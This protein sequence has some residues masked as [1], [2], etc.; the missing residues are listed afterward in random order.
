MIRTD[1]LFRLI[2]DRRLQLGLSQSEVGRRSLGQSDGSA[3]QNIRRGS[4]PTFENL[5]KICEVLGLRVSI[6]PVTGRSESG[7]SALCL[8]RE[9]CADYSPIPILDVALAAGTGRVNDHEVI[10]SHLA[11][12]SD[13]LRGLGLSAASSVVARAAGESMAPTIHDG[14]A[15][16]IDRARAIPPQH[17]REAKDSRPA[18]IYALFDENGARIKRLAVSSPGV[19]ALL[20]D[21]PEYPPDFLPADQVHIIGRVMWW[22]HTNRED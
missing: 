20:S 13:W 9:H 14:D 7:D 3:I 21:N 11:F 22:G 16:L 18:P 8:D 12:R 2:E 17:P 10:I 4:S 6:E 5:Q 19:L 1:A 15:V